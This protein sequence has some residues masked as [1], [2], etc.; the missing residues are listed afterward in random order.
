MAIDFKGFIELIFEDFRDEFE[1]QKYERHI[2]LFEL[3]DSVSE[4]Y[5]IDLAIFLINLT[6]NKRKFSLDIE[7]VGG[8]IVIALMKSETI[9]FINS[10]DNA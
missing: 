5:L 6:Y 10:N 1:Y 2:P 4:S 9:E 8:K 3:V 7:N